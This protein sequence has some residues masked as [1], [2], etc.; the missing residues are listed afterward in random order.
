MLT[1]AINILKN[2]PESIDNEELGELL[3]LCEN[4]RLRRKF[5]KLIHA[6]KDL[7]FLVDKRIHICITKNGEFVCKTIENI[8]VG[9]VDALMANMPSSIPASVLSTLDEQLSSERVL[10]ESTEA[11]S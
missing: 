4:L 8:D 1:K 7:G 9:D 3:G 11:N 5:A 2:F 6:Q 10:R